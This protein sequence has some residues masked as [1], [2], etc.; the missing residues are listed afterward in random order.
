M[1]TV[2]V[3]ED[4]VRILREE[5]AGRIMVNTVEVVRVLA[6]AK[7]GPPGVG[8]KGDTGDTGPE[9]P[10]APAGSFEWNSTGN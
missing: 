6:V 10:A 3:H 8:L 7:Q 4:T 5:P 2:V 9:G 1:S